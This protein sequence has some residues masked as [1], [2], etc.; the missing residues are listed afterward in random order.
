[1]TPETP[2]PE[3]DAAIIDG[4][5][6]CQEDMRPAI[7]FCANLERE[8]DAALAEIQ[9][10]REAIV[11]ASEALKELRSFYLDMTRLPPCAANAALAKLKPFLP[12]AP[13][14]KP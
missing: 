7:S 4:Y 5:T 12:D 14:T 3:T 11:E 2:T 13:P 8:R 9:A 6:F 1:M 10:M